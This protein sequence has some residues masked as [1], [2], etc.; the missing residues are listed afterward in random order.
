MKNVKRIFLVLVCSLAIIVIFRGWLYRHCVNYTILDYRQ[1]Y[2]PDKAFRDF[3]DSKKKDTKIN[4]VEDIIK[5]S[6]KITSDELSFT[7][8][9]CEYNPNSLIHSQKTNCIGYS[10][11]FNSTCNYLLTEYEYDWNSLSLVGQQQLFGANINKHLHSAFFKDHD[12]N[13]IENKK[14]GEKYFVDPTVNDYLWID[15]V[16][17]K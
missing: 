9:K 14:T 8:S 5:L 10:A 17:S 13:V 4:S 15:F 12:F 6:L 1:S 11:F 2:T 3:V 16:S 7:T